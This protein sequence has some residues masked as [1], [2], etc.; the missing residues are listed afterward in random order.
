MISY[1]LSFRSYGWDYVF[2]AAVAFVAAVLLS[3][4]VHEYAHG[5]IALRCGDTTAKDSGRLTLNPRAHFSVIG[6]L[7]FLLVGIGFAKPVPI[8]VANFRNPRRDIFKV[9]VAGVVANFIMAF[10]S[11]GIMSL[12]LLIVGNGSILS[13]KIVYYIFFL[14]VEFCIVSIVINIGLIAFNLIPVYPLDGFRILASFFRKRN[15]VLDFLAKY[16][17]YILLALMIIGRI[18]PALDILSMYVSF[19]REMV[20]KLFGLIFPN[21]STLGF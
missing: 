17:M 14:L 12:F 19:I 5:F 9:S 6:I 3:V 4:T 1:V 10:I 21:L 11:A 20:F 2:L 13:H 7:F 16:G 8:D 18:F 15:A